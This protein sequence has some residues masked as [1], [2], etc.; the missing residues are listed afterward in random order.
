[1]SPPQSELL[2]NQLR[3]ARRLPSPPGTALRVLELCRREDTE[4]KQIADAIMSDPALSARLLRYANSPMAGAGRKVTSVRDA[5]L[6]LGLRAV[7]LTALGF[8]FASPELQP[9]CPGFE[10]RRFW[11]ESFAT[12]VIARRLATRPFNADREEAFTAGLLA[13]IGR[14]AFAHGLPDD[15]QRV[16]QDAQRGKPLLEAERETF[17]LDH[18]E[19]GAQLLAE[20]GLPG[21]LVEAVAGQER[22]ADVQTPG[23]SAETLARI[24]HLASRLAPVFVSATELEAAVRDRAREVIDNVLGL[25]EEAWQQM[26]EE[27]LSEYCQ[28]AE[29]F[30][31]QL[32]SHVS[33]FDLYAEAQEEATRVGMVANLER[34]R[35]LEENKAL[36][37]RA[38]TDSLTG[39]ANRAKFEE[40]LGELLA[41]VR[42]GKDHFALILFD[43]DHF[44]RFN[45]TYGHEV[46]DLVLKH[47]AHTARNVLREVDL[48][49]RFGGEEFV[50]LAPYTDQ[51]GACTIAARVR[52]AVAEERVDVNGLSL[53]VTISVG[54]ALSSDYR[55]PPDA[56]QIVADADKQLYL[57]KR[58]GRNTWSYLGRT[59]SEVGR[60]VSRS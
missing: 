3:S 38:T 48:L 4:V 10:L 12:A 6:L 23:S 40:R 2:V 7:K 35:A 49:A 42:R 29:L 56:E 20:W 52:R 37:R 60:V 55:Q 31:I 27:I 39:I 19:F 54:L 26:A 15:Y 50:I 34:S 8:S 16:L 44:K 51:R 13:G 30:D 57:S 9:H 17:G 41:S 47:V 5:V 32:D 58:A 45:D 43:I 25:D 33:A 53:G 21:V 28:V 24:V 59:A 22:A 1:M 11:A 14:L 36:L 46:G 18:V